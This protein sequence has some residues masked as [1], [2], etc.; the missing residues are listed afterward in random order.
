[1]LFSICFAITPYATPD[2][3]GLV[4][5]R[6]KYILPSGVP[7]FSTWLT[8]GYAVG[9]PVEH[10]AGVFFSAR[11]TG[12][13]VKFAAA[14]ATEFEQE[15]VYLAGHESETVSWLVSADRNCREA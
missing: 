10:G 7:G 6:L 9:W 4:A 11:S 15:L 13:A 3:A 8:C 2:D 1:M 14:I 12:A 5:A